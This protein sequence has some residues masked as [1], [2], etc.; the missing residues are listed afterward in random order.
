MRAGP[1][2]SIVVIDTL[3][4]FINLLIFKKILVNYYHEYDIS[5]ML[6]IKQIDLAIEIA[7]ENASERWSSHRHHIETLTT[8]YHRVS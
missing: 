2:G 3:L 5:I 1:L 6:E 4:Y 8:N 7:F